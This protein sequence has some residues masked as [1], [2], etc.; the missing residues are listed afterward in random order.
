VAWS[1]LF[2]VKLLRGRDS[3]ERSFY[4]QV[5]RAGS[6]RYTDSGRRGLLLVLL[7]GSGCGIRTFSRSPVF[8]TCSN[9]G[10]G[11]GLVAVG[12][13]TWVTLRRDRSSVGLDG[14]EQSR[15]GETD[16]AARMPGGWRGV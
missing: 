10:G 4:Q 3:D 8:L 2:Q 11:F 14:F 13:V 7:P 1:C 12:M 15:S 5:C 16:M 6:R 9:R